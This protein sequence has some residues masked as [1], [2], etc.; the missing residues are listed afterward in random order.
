MRRG[1]PMAN[2]LLTCTGTGIV[3]KVR[4]LSWEVWRRGCRT[5]PV[6]ESPPAWSPDGS[7]IACSVGHPRG[8]RLTFLNVDTRD[9]EQPLRDKALLWQRAPSW[10]AAGDR[11]AISGNKHPLP[12]IL[13]RDLHNAWADK[14]TIFIVNR[15]GSGL[16]QL[17]EEAGPGGSWACIIAGTA[18]KWFIHRR[19]TDSCKSSRLM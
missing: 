7:E 10:S 15:D 11:L 6:W 12:V 4:S 14:S 1:L 19:L 9:R 3:S 18:R 13:D 17:V 8:V 16:R 5:S 2:G